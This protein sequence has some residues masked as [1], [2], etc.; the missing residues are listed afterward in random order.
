MIGVFS[1]KVHVEVNFEGGY[2]SYETTIEMIEIFTQPMES[3]R[4]K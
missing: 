1:N 4:K 2:K 3:C